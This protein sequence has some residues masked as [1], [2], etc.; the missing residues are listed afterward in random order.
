MSYENAPATKMLATC[1][2]ACGRPLLDAASVEAG[3]GPDCRAKHGYYAEPSAPDWD[4]AYAALD[5]AG[6]A[7]KAPAGWLTDARRA[8]N[9]LVHRVAAE[10]HSAPPMR[11][12]YM[13][14][15]VRALGFSKL[16]T[17]LEKRYAP[18]RVSERDGL[19]L[20]RT[21]FDGA[22][23]TAL[24]GAKVGAGWLKE[25]KTWTVPATDAGRKALWSALR[26]AFLGSPGVGPKGAF[27]VNGGAL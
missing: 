17:A 11:V 24:K 8:S 25:A 23:V 20:V 6:L 16:A 9:V 5:K 1:C 21:P 10:Q 12:L 7:A 13:V 14:A 3:M 18:I 2:A 22:F 26:A 27:V 15:A 19:L 4:A